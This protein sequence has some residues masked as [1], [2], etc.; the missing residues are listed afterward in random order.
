MSLARSAAGSGPVGTPSVV[1]RLGAWIAAIASLAAVSILASITVAELSSGEA[2]AINL[3]GSL[4]MQ[5]Y[6]I[7]AAAGRSDDPTRLA[8]TLAEFDTRY[9]SA[10]LI[11]VIPSR[12]DDPVRQA[13]AKVGETWQ[14]RFRPVVERSIDGHSD[15]SEV[16]S[17]TEDIVGQIDHLVALV[18]EGLEAKLQLLRIAQG[19]SLILLL[20]VGA[21]TVFQLKRHVVHP[22][23]HLL[24]SARIVRRGDFGVRIPPREP[25]ELGQLG[26]AF[27]YMV[28]DLSQLYAQ[29]ESRVQEKT[30][31]LALSNQSLRLLYRTTRALSEKTATRET[32]L[33]VLQEVDEVI[34]IRAVAL[35]LKKADYTDIVPMD[36]TTAPAMLEALI[37]AAGSETDGQVRTHDDVAGH[38][39]LIS[40]PLF[41]GTLSH[42]AM[43]LARPDGQTLAPW[44]I[45]LL[46]TVGRHVGAALATSQR[47]EEQHRLALL[48][49]RSVIARE[50]HDSLAQ[51]LSY[52]KIQVTRLQTMLGRA[53]TPDP[54]HDVVRELRD[55][56][57]EAYRQLRELLTTFRLR[58]DG[59]G[60]PAAID[61][62]VR[63]FHRRTGLTPLLDNQLGGI[64][65]PPSREIHVL[66]IIREALSNI[67]RHARATHVHIRLEHAD[68]GLLRVNIDDDGVGF[69]PQA[70]PLHR[71]GLVIMRDRAQSLDGELTIAHRAGGGTRV[72]L[73]FPANENPVSSQG[74]QP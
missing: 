47:N 21:S 37:Q 56:L 73:S 57:S 38:A 17:A 25:D 24:T 71:Y 55:G 32:L 40:V 19:I 29:L 41:D 69:D 27:N 64:A 45:E 54:V 43:L 53:P 8:A 12:P 62:A 70:L 7:G 35:C 11:R 22:L 16:R 31:E 72:A 63:D 44:Q 65:L 26:E 9:R 30:E 6:V 10:D 33:Q 13:Y 3:A 58:I 61:D 68:D 39:P 34:G 48:D 4:R 20:I 60:L 28:A 18:E 15:D 23:E 51:S 36:G 14:L 49:E 46:E 66:Q 2:R 52:L 50:L 74:K 1:R 42:G 5:S 67:E 59:R